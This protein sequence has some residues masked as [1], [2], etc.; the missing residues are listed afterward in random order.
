MNEYDTIIID[1]MLPRK[2]G[3]PLCRAIRTFNTTFPILF[4]TARNGDGSIESRR[5]M[6]R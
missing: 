1:M 3:F 5:I 4:L 6:K 2:R